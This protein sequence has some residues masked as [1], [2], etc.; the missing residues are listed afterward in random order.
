M[1]DVPKPDCC[2]SAEEVYRSHGAPSVRR[3]A[4]RAGVSRAKR[5]MLEAILTRSFEVVLLAKESYLGTL[6]LSRMT[7]VSESHH[8]N[9]IEI[10]AILSRIC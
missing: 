7:T 9:V 4:F 8:C 1:I 10:G 3:P 6:P 5:T 2:V